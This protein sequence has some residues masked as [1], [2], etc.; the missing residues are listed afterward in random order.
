[1]IK[2][3]FLILFVF[4]INLPINLSAQTGEWTLTGSLNQPRSEHQ[5]VLLPDG[6]V[7]IA[8]GHIGGQGPTSSCEI[9]NPE[10]GEWT[11]TDSMSTPRKN[12]VKVILNNGKVLAIGGRTSQVYDP[13]TGEWESPDSMHY[14]R[15][16]F[17]AVILTNGKVLAV[18]GFDNADR[19][20]A[21]IYDPETGEW[22]LTG[23]LNE[24][25]VMHTATLLPNG[26]VLV[27][28]DSNSNTC[29]IYDPESGEWTYTDS[30]NYWRMQ[31]TATLL[32]NGKPLI[33]GGK[34][35]GDIWLSSSDLYN[36]QTG[37][38]SEADS[39]EIGRCCHPATL[40]P[41]GK[42]VVNGGFNFELNGATPLKSS[43]IYDPSTELWLTEGEM[44]I[45]RMNHTSIPLL[46]GRVLTVG[47]YNVGPTELYSW[48]HQPQADVP[49]GPSEAQPGDTLVFTTTG[50]DP[51]GDSISVRFSWD[52]G[53]TADWTEYQ[54]SGHTFE[55]THVWLDSGEYSI[56]VQVR[57]SW[58]PEG[59]HNS[60]S[61]WSN[62]LVVTISNLPEP[63]NPP[64][65]RELEG[66]PTGL[67]GNTL[68]FTTQASDPDSDSVTVRFVWDE[69]D[70]SDWSEYQASGSR[71]DIFGDTGTYA[72]K[73]QAK[74]NRQ[75]ESNWSDSLVV[76]ISD[77][78]VGIN[79]EPFVPSEFALNQNYPNP[80]NPATTIDYSIPYSGFVSLII[81]N[82]HGEE[83][84]RPLNEQQNSGTYRITWDASNFSSG[85]YFY[86]LQASPP[87]GGFTQT[88]KMLLL[89]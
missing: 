32:P 66:P 44:N 79:P 77:S 53:D 82:I 40:L 83:I 34:A 19:N 16:Y 38:W 25:R 65:I 12:F 5:A 8:G 22:T 37:T 26:K 76:T 36:P 87:A 20:S 89:K 31:L 88:R 68:V 48:N 70:T 45:G 61:N 1:M 11:Y 80:F 28:G 72:V 35:F 10:T 64:E 59:I 43:E 55:M 17:D 81:F 78:T 62:P 54:S 73:T 75:A 69:S 60:I 24:G 2:R 63:N 15:Q 13:E 3:L 18:G 14:V 52:D 33:T 6:T 30:L 85:I 49:Q 23:F 71:F 86:R 50:T 29:E 39:L 42:V 67:V 47:G 27:A 51:D 41:N 9:Y 4:S 56:T 58:Q 21:E 46:D 74:D 7:L 84:S 57:D